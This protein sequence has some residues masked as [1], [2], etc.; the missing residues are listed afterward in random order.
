MGILDWFKNRPAQFDPDRLS[1]EMTLRAIDK[2]VTLTNP[3]LKLVHS[4]QERLAPAVETS[5]HYLRE[6]VLALPP[7][8]RISTENWSADP[9]LRAFFVAAS[10]IPSA[11]SRSHNLRTLFEKYP[12]LDDAYFILGMMFNEQ[13]V[14]GMSLQGDVIQRDVAQTVI[15]FSDHQARICG[16]EDSEVRRLLGSQMYEYLVAQALSEIGEERSERR[17][18]EDNRA[19][20]RAR[21]RLFQQQ[22]PGLGSVFGS[23]PASSGEQL[24]LEAELLENEQQMEAIG[25]PQSALDN[26]LEL[27]REVL[28]HPGRYVRI[29]QKQLRL[30]TMNVVLEASSTDV[31]SDIAFSIAQLTGVP[32]LQSAFVLARF[33]RSELPPARMNFEVAERYL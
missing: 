8:I 25:S 24:K 4:Y 12:E 28:E 3:R 33:A 10:D 29:E 16:H 20:I 23:A 13:R 9:I 21:L 26:E 31:A 32:R 2:A 5:V 17:E 11:L 30:S 18:L 1:D 27:L 22:G 7:A 6:M 19:L 15:S 14:L